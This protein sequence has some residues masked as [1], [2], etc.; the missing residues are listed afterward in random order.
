MFFVWF[1]VACAIIVALAVVGGMM[2][3]HNPGTAWENR[4]DMPMGPGLDH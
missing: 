3:R 4:E 1:L 2:A